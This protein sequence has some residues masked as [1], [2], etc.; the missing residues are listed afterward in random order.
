MVAD[1]VADADAA[2]L[3]LEQLDPPA[4]EEEGR[5]HAV[6]LQG[7]QDRRHAVGVGAGG[8]GERDHVAAGVEH[9]QLPA[10]ERGRDALAA[11]VAG[12]AAGRGEPEVAAQPVG[13]VEVGSAGLVAV[14]EQPAA[15]ALDADGG[16]AVAVPVPHHSLSPAWP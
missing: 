10:P 12:P 3:V 2:G 15:A 1:L 13:E 5:G 8:E 9:G 16:G 14:A 11:A 6:P 4:G 7:G